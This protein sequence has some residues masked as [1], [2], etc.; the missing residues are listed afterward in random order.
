MDPVV[1]MIHHCCHLTVSFFGVDETLCVHAALVK[2]NHWRRRRAFVARAQLQIIQL[3]EYSVV[4]GRR[5]CLH[6]ANH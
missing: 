1:T 3:R 4:V 6:C 2:I 5:P